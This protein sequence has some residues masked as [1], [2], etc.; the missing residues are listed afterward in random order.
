MIFHLDIYKVENMWYNR[1]STNEKYGELKM[2]IQEEANWY[3][4]WRV[5]LSAG[6]LESKEGHLISTLADLVGVLIDKVGVLESK[7]GELDNQVSILER[8]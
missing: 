5:E 7:L 3:K 1:N 2:D 8:G 6:N 4:A